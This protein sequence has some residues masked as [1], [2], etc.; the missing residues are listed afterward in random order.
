LDTESER[1]IQDALNQLMHQCT[2]IVIAHR[3][4]TIKEANKIIVMDHSRVL[5]VGK[6]EEL[7]VRQGHYAK[8]YDMQFKDVD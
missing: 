5:E 7:L 4:S 3:L 8:L 6:H 2:T 1:Y